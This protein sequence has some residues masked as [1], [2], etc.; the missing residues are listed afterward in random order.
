[1]AAWETL[2]GETPIDDISGLLIKGISTPRE[3]SLHEAENI[4]KALVKYLGK[5]PSRRRAPFDYAWTLKL[6][7]EMFGEV[8]SW[9][10]VP[11]TTDLNVGVPCHQV[12][13][14]LYALL[15]DLRVWPD[16]LPL[17]ATMLHHRAVHIH[18]FMNGN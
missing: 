15:E 14:S 2:P 1:M 6:H 7:R 16:A 18:P 9:A 3:L 5:R 11:R 13:A 10:G 17:Q 12:E 8:W 4:R